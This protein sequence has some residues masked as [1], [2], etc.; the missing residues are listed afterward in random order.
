VYE[1]T[2]SRSACGLHFRRGE[3]GGTAWVCSAGVDDGWSGALR[4]QRDQVGYF[5][6]SLETQQ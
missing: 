1:H 5:V 3:V 6:V 4:L 2:V